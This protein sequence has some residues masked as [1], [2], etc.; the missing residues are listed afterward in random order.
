VRGGRGGGGDYGKG[1]GAHHHHL[2]HNQIMVSV[3]LSC[4]VSERATGMCVRV[5]S[6]CVR[7]G[8]SR[9]LF[10]VFYNSVFLQRHAADDSVRV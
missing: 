6:A 9:G 3:T 4:H 7:V 8:Q 1:E 5:F 10:C 2:H